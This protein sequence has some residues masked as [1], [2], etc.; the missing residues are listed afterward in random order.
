MAR[1]FDAIVVGSGITGGWAAKELSERGLTVLMLERGKPIEHAVDYRGEHVP[2]WQQRFRGVGDRRRFAT[3]YA[4]QS[5]NQDFEDANLSFWANDLEEPYVSDPEGPFHWTRASCL[6]GRSLVWGRQVYRWS[7][8][9]FEANAREGHG[10]DWPLRYRDLAPWYDHVE[11]FI[12]VS[13][14]AEGLAHL[15]DGIFLPPMELNCVELHAKAKIEAAFPGRRLTI[16]R[17]AILTREHR[18]RAACHYCGPCWRGCSTGSYFSTQSST[19][20][21]ARATGRLAV[22]TH[23][24]VAR[25]LYDPRRRRASG[26]EVVDTRTG[27]RRE[28]RARLVFLCAST[29]ASARV[30]LHSRSEHFPDGLANSS[31]VLG[32]YL[33]DHILGPGA[34]GFVPGFLE[35]Y[36]QGNRPNGIYIP[37][38]RN[39][40]RR[41]PGFVRGYGYQGAALRLGWSRGGF[42]PGFGRAFKEELRQPGP[43]L[44]VLNGFGECLPYRENRVSLDPEKVDAWGIP[45][46]RVRFNW[47]ENERAMAA[48]ITAQAVAMLEAA[49]AVNVIPQE[50]MYVGGKAIHEMGTARMGS[51]PRSSVLNAWNQCH[52]VPNLFVTDGSGM[53]SSACQNPS[54]TYMAFTARAAAH[55]TEELTRGLA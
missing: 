14:Q 16:G 53:V 32:H 26:V 10:I 40:A 17:A 4:V 2:P 12:G 38:F 11:S 54:L 52:D 55:A 5:D 1:D 13:G 37:R 44:L 49:G 29:L 18:G 51:D 9:D 7:D 27:E 23:A 20:P 50:E 21:A 48:D 43:W 24:L 3:E 41:E 39:L 22:E 33:M 19:L 6:G 15:P 34:I 35:H 46:L 30:L 25:V 47:G 28:V 42:Q 31:G 8:L 45:Q 36:Y